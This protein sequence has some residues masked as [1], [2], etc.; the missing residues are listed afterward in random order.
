MEVN[1]EGM[2]VF[3]VER[4]EFLEDFVYFRIMCGLQSSPL[5]FA[6]NRAFMCSLLQGQAPGEI[7]YLRFAFS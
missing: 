7:M 5:V 3:A 6:P 1:P 2:K 4:Q